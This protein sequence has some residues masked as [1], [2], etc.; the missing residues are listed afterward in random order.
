MARGRGKRRGGATQSRRKT[1]GSV[2]GV[3]A[4]YEEML[5]EVESSPAQTGDEGRVIK[6]RRVKGRMVAQDGDGPERP[7][8]SPVPAPRD[9]DDPSR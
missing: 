1:A 6:K 9:Q 7:S 2:V 8:S 3:G 5:A 4:A